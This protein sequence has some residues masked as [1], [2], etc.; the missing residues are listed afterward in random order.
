MSGIKEHIDAWYKYVEA[1]VK[2]IEEDPEI[3]A[4]REAEDLLRNIVN[5]HYQFSGCHSFS[6]KRVYNQAANHKNEIDLIIVTQKKL[7]MLECKN[8]GGRLKKEN[9][10]W[11]QYKRNRDGSFRTV[12]HDDVVEKNEEKRKVLLNYLRS[13]GISISNKDCVQR[14]ILMNR[15]LTIDSPEIYND[16]R[17]IPPDQLDNYLNRQETR[18]KLH[19]R[20]FA[21]VISI[22]LTKK[23]R[24]R[25]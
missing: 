20:F 25:L 3:L 4:G 18:L 6:S 24:K 23:S 15:N 16:S 17:V 12:S 19:E 11:V 13:Q 10:S 14:I 21:S 22:C 5:A 2:A 8:W 7:Y 1:D 9:G